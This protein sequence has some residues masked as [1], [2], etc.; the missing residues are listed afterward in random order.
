[1]VS[2]VRIV[3]GVCSYTYNAFLKE[4]YADPEMYAKI[5]LYLQNIF[6]SKQAFALYENCLDYFDEKK[7]FGETPFIPLEKLRKI[8]GVKENEYLDF[9]IFNRDV[10]K[11]AAKYI[12]KISDLY[13]DLKNKD[14]GVEYKR[15]KRKVVAVK[16]RIQRNKD[17]AIDLKFLKEK[18]SHSQ[19]NLPMEEFE[20]EN[21]ELLKV[22]VDDFAIDKNSAMNTTQLECKGGANW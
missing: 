14:Q 21:Q 2:G 19:L 17:N 12:N 15:E 13:I 5:H 8:F 11:K 9:P 6:Q 16:F 3:N 1:L 18:T 22:L 7:G 10:V 4:R 20:I